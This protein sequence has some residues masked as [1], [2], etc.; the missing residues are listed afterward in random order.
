MTQL[1]NSSETVTF[2]SGGSPNIIGANTLYANE[3]IYF[4]AGT[5]PK[6]STTLALNTPYY[7]VNGGA[8]FQISTTRGGS[9]ITCT[10]TG[11]GVTAQSA[12]FLTAAT[13]TTITLDVDSSGFGTYTSGGS[14]VGAFVTTYLHNFETAAVISPALA[15]YELTNYRNFYA[16]GGEFPSE[17]GYTGD[18]VW[19]A[20]YASLYTA[21]P[22]P[23]IT[24]AQQ[25]THTPYLLKRDLEPMSNDN[26]PLGIDLAA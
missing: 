10:T 14:S 20:Y 8:T 13:A 3:A 11:S 19:A 7:V 17:Y 26:T 16:Q 18:N 22:T 12:W 24:A 21:L 1:N 6:C 5:L 9:A 2:A 25:F 15:I 23:K 4:A